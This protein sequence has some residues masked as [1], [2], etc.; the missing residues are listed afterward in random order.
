MNSLRARLFAADA[1][2]ACPDLA[3]TIGIGAVLTRRQVDKTQVSELAQRADDFAQTRRAERQLREPGPACRRLR[4]VVAPRTQLAPYVP[5]SR[6]RA[7][8]DD[9]RWHAVSLLVPHDPR[10]GEF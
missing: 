9:L 10:N 5:T 8:D 2:S 7:T 4:V 1:R 3:L 6:T